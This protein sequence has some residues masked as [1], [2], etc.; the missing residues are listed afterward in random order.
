[1]TITKSRRASRRQSQSVEF[2]PINSNGQRNGYATKPSSPTTTGRKNNNNNNNTN[3]NNN[4]ANTNRTSDRNEE[5][6]E[7]DGR[8]PPP[9]YTQD[10]D[11]EWQQ[12]Q[13]QQQQHQHQSEFLDE[14]DRRMNELQQQHRP[15]RLDQTGDKYF[16]NEQ[17]R[18]TRI[19][20]DQSNPQQEQQDGQQPAQTTQV[21][22]IEPLKNPNNIHEYL[23]ALANKKDDKSIISSLN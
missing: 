16:V 2:P 23:Y 8:P 18:L 11:G 15:S 7:N 19:D 21:K 4:N 3:T 5:N 22:T 17:G 6:E 1:V 14:N 9:P 12:Q 10:D 20:D 13:Q